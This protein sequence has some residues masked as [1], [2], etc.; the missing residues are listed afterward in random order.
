MQIVKDF[1]V[2]FFDVGKHFKSV[3]D[4][5]EAFR[6]RGFFK[7]LIHLD[8]ALVVFCGE[9]K[10]FRQIPFFFE[11][12]ACVDLNIVDFVFACLLNESVEE[13][14]VVKLV[15][16]HLVHDFGKRVVALV[17]RAVFDKLIAHVRLRFANVRTGE[18]LIGFAF[19]KFHSCLLLVF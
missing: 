13:S 19:D 10:V 17:A 15:V 6:T 16:H 5:F 9:S 14:C 12:I 3:C 11:R 1:L 7:G 18:V 8:F 2:L 4:V